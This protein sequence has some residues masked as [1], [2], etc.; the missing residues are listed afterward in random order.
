MEKERAQHQR[1]LEELK[2]QATRHLEKEK[3]EYQQALETFKAKLTRDNDLTGQTLR[4]KISLYK[5]A[6]LPIIDLVLQHN[7]APADV[8]PE[9]LRDFER[10]RL[11]TSA[12]LG[13]FA[14][15]P[16]FEAYNVLIDYTF[17]CLEAKRTFVF[18]DFRALGF[19]MM[20]QIRRDVGIVGDD[21]VYRGPRL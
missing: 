11:M 12:L 20:S 4:E 18:A 1:G 8:T 13:M 21:L 5:A 19:A 6:L 14:P 2:A 15:L 10:K 7:I 16:V 17:D 3:A 9:L